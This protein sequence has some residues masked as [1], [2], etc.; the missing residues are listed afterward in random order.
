[1][2]DFKG[3]DVLVRDMS[4]IELDVISKVDETR[5]EFERFPPSVGPSL[6]A[7]SSNGVGS[8]LCDRPVFNTEAS[9]VIDLALRSSVLILDKGVDGVSLSARCLV[10]GFVSSAFE[11]LL[12]PCSSFILEPHPLP[13]TADPHPPSPAVDGH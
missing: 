3:A 7:V 12:H 4:W 8:L 11:L 9:L 10:E 6:L 1:L 13:L 5:T 2:E